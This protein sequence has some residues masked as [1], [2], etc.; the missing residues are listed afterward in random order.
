MIRPTDAPRDHQ[1]RIFGRDVAIQTTGTRAGRILLEELAAYPAASGTPDLTVTVSASIDAP[2][3]G[4][5]NPA[6]HQELDDGFIARLPGVALRARWRDGNLRGLDLSTPS[7]SGARNTVARW[8]NRQ[9]TDPEEM[10]GQ[11]FHE[12]AA[13]LAA[14]DS[15]GT[16]LLHATA[17]SVSGRAIAIGGTGGVGKTT[18]GVELCLRHGA[19]FLADDLTVVT[20]DGVVQ[21]NLAYPKIY[22]YNLRGDAELFRRVFEGR[23]AGDRVQ[24]STKRW[25]NDLGARRRVAPDQLY[26]RTGDPTTLSRYLLVVRE[27]RPDLVVESVDAGT[28][29][30]Q[31]TDVL[32]TEVES[33]A[34]HLWWHRYDRRI[35]GSAPLL[36][37]AA[38]FQRWE[39]GL[40]RILGQ[41][42]CQVVRVPATLPIEAYRARMSELV[43][44]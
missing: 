42:E 40:E 14:M 22:A 21:P 37:V 30:R 17:V 44:G 2:L 13:V 34:R 24:W 16:F 38:V 8:R 12:V 7:R 36:D 41:V 3:T 5:I 1:F 39:D 4:L 23:P 6:S 27:H 19:A 10:V 25:R 15:P 28:L 18:I 43:L 35:L 32:R 26:G 29:A 33:V 31:T 20:S 11:K 9:F